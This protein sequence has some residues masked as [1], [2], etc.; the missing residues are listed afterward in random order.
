MSCKN[1]ELEEIVRERDIELEKIEKSLRGATSCDSETKKLQGALSDGEE[2]ELATSGL[3][4]REWYLKTY[5]DVAAAGIDPWQHFIKLGSSEGR[6][7]NSLFDSKWYLDTNPDVAAAGMNPVIHYVRHGGTEGRDPSKAFDSDWYLSRYPDVAEAGMNPLVH[8]LRHGVG[9]GRSPRPAGR[10][11]DGK[12]PLPMAKA[13]PLRYMRPR[14][15]IVANVDLAQCTMYR[16]W[17]KKRQFESLGVKCTVVDWTKAQTILNALQ[18]HSVAIFYRIPGFAEQLEQI[19]EAHRLGNLVFWESDDLIFDGQ[20]YHNN[21]NLQT[22]DPELRKSVLSGVPLFL[23]ALEASGR[24]IAS[25]EKI[26][27][28]MRRYGSPAFVIENGIDDMTLQ[29]MERLRERRRNL[30]T[31]TTIEVFYGSGTLAHNADFACAAHG[32]GRAMAQ[33]PA[34]R[35]RIVGELKLGPEL[36][37]FAG[38]ID[39]E[40]LCDYRTYLGKLAAADINIAPLE[41]SEFNHAKSNIKFLEAAAL[42]IPTI[43]SPT[44]TFARAIKSGENGWLAVDNEGWFQAVSTLAQRYDLRQDFGNAA[45]D[46]A[47]T[48]YRLKRITEQQMRPMLQDL[49]LLEHIEAKT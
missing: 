39:R 49:G 30:G 45:L 8:Y 15:L 34:M 7:P 33:C 38:R 4:D 35:L 14:V 2:T 24:G 29:W 20:A 48:S 43:A 9:E 10:S 41:M 1:E 40:P 6:N 46:T 16:V 27:D 28:Y 5:L 36:R 18:T 21:L 37:E 11:L 25:T 17:Q 44:E 12:H 47:L 13:S 32:L 31:R 19:E 3:F 22:L 26:A 23:K 42:R